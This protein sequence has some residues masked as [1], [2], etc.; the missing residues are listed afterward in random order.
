M[1]YA[2]QVPAKDGAAFWVML[3]GLEGK[4]RSNSRKFTLNMMKP[5]YIHVSTIMY[6]YICIFNRPTKKATRGHHLTTL[7]GYPHLP[8]VKMG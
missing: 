3:L 1:G 5:E 4:N 8:T 7:M 6:I 2:Q